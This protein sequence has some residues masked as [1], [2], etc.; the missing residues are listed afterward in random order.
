MPSTDTLHPYYDNIEND[1]WLRA[2]L[3]EVRPV[4]VRFLVDPPASWTAV[5]ADRV[6]R[7]FRAFG[8]N[9]L[10]AVHAAQS[11]SGMQ[12][13]LSR[14]RDARGCCGGPHTSGG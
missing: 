3:N 8:L 13:R 7:H 4:S 5:F 2:E 12:W 6:A 14:T 10:Y 11:I 9:K 1:L